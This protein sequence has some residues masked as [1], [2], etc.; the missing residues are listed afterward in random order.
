YWK[1]KKG[2]VKRKSSLIAAARRRTGGGIEDL[3]QLSEIELKIQT[4]M[5][6]ESFGCGDQ[7]FFNIVPPNEQQA[8]QSEEPGYEMQWSNLAAFDADSVQDNLAQI[9]QVPPA[10]DAHSPE[11]EE[12]R[13]SLT[14]LAR[15]AA[16]PNDVLERGSQSMMHSL[17]KYLL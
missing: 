7:N 1:D 12:N 3:P 8:N 5:R 9:P 13:V 10:P 14:E 17:T 11:D 16:H 6:G 15:P 2:A 4:I